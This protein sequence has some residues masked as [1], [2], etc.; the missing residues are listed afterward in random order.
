V[1]VQLLGVRDGIGMQCMPWSHE[2]LMLL[3][4]RIESSFE[5]VRLHIR[6]VYMNSIL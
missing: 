6:L 1:G 4:S 2:G 5:C 3:Y